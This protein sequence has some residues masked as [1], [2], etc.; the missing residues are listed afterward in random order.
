MP[1]QKFKTNYKKRGESDG[2]LEQPKEMT[3]EFEISEERRNRLIDWITFYRRNI[4]RFVQHYFGI[5]LYPY[6]IIWIYMMSLSD[7]FV[8]IC[9]RAI[10][11]SWLIAVFACAR[12]VLYPNSEI[13]IVSSTKEQAGK[14][15][16]DKIENLRANYPNLNREISKTTLNPNKWQVDFYNGSTIKVVASRDSARGG[17][18]N[19]LIMEEFRLI[20]KTVLDSVIRPFA[21]IRQAPYLKNKEY[22]HLVEEAKE[23]FISSAYHKGLW[24]FEE[25]KKNIRAMAKGE[26]AGFIAIDFWPSV[27]HRIKTLKDI[28]NEISRMDEITALEEVYNKPW[29][30]SS[31]AYY[32]LKMFQRSRKL[33][34]AFYPQRNE[35]YDPKKNPFGIHKTEGELRIISCDVAQMGGRFNDLSVSTCLRLLPTTKG[36][37]I[38]VCYIESF[39]GVNSIT[40]TVRIKQL[41]YDFEADYIVL[42]VGAG[43]GGVPMYDSLGQVLKD[44]ERGIE[45]PAMTVINDPSID[46]SKYDE[47]LHRTLGVNALPVIYPIVPIGSL[48][49]TMAVELR[50]K[51]QKRMI[52]FLI[53]E[54]S[55]EDYLITSKYKDIFMD[56]DD[57]AGKAVL[58][59]PYVQTSLLINECI[60]LS[61][62]LVGGNIKLTEPPNSRKDRFSSLLYGCHFCSILDKSLL[63][64]DEIDEFSYISSLVQTA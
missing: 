64:E 15:V 6:Q 63:R 3:K 12:A 43:G 20:D 50:D 37:E 46:S 56:H 5:S 13:V 4:H 19:F 36:Y 32:K 44:S 8:A 54:N 25:T 42:D 28:K 60:N 49:S 26:N 7:S 39:S 47:L 35:K 59:A 24:W 52:K 18:S 61:M 16:S 23:V 31:A 30:E 40:Q 38:N 21:Y 11:K 55:A 2:I 10:G 41:Y 33:D 34:L 57:V 45:Y 17:R 48:N 62:S 9:S 27:R 22:H 29:G 14:I 58:I 53:D 51:L 1:S